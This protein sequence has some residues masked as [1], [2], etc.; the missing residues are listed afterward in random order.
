MESSKSYLRRQM[1]RKLDKKL[2]S[3]RVLEDAK[4]LKEYYEKPYLSSELAN[5]DVKHLLIALF[6]ELKN[7]I[8]E[9]KSKL[10][11]F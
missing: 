11:T 7:D 3:N 6:I 8:N 10:N 5:L 1:L 2:L 4:E 9:I